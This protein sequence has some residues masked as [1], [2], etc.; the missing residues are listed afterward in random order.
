MKKECQ[1]GNQWGVDRQEDQEI[2][3]RVMCVKVMNVNN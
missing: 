1:I 3:G 2:D